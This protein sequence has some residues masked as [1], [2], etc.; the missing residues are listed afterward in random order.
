MFL[1]DMSP[2]KKITNHYHENKTQ[3]P[4]IK[5]DTKKQRRKKSRP[6]DYIY[7]IKLSS[8]KVVKTYVSSNLAKQYDSQKSHK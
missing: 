6:G 2:M 7:I 5:Q 8:E 4:L 1:V 3:S